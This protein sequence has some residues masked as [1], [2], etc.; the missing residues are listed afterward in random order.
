MIRAPATI[1]E[2]D[3][4]ELEEILGRVE[5]QQL[6]ADDFQT[7][8]T[9][10]ESYVCLTQAVGNKNTTIRRL[11]QMLF[12]VKT[13]KTAAVIGSPLAADKKQAEVSPASTANRARRRTRKARQPHRQRCSAGEAE[14]DSPTPG[15]R[16]RPQRGRRL[17]GRREDRGP[18]SLAGPWRSV[19]AMRDG[20]G[21]R[22]GPSGRDGAA[23]WS[24]SRGR[25]GLLSAKAAPVNCVAWSS[26]PSCLKRRA[27]RSTTPPSAA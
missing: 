5:A 16:P 6:R 7:I 21:L 24:G 4:S 26:P 13:E 3:M 8:R 19:P 2:L 15:P 17:R 9:L 10:I 14:S 1:V 25:Q 27:R 22:H 12:G 11:R 20:H 18:A 23:G